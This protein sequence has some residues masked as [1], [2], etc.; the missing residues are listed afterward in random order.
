MFSEKKKRHRFPSFGDYKEH[1]SEL[2]G[3]Y[4]LMYFLN[5]S[6][7]KLIPE[8]SLKKRKQLKKLI[9]D[10]PLPIVNPN[11]PK[12]K[13]E[14]LFIP[15][16]I[17]HQHK[18][19]DDKDYRTKSESS[20]KFASRILKNKPKISFQVYNIPIEYSCKRSSIDLSTSSSK[21]RT[22]S[23][24]SCDSNNEIQENPEFIN[25]FK[26]KFSSRDEINFIKG[27]KSLEK[28]FANKITSIIGRSSST[29]K[30]RL[31]AIINKERDIDY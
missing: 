3:I 30:P 5:I 9:E 20:I 8:C 26:K 11:L 23:K 28:Q 13:P 31:A 18:T 12:I 7:P 29:K 19:S 22:K 15:N 1:T 21:K 4:K 14:E 6:H 2:K 16:L 27:G 25:I 24:I 17:T 10:K